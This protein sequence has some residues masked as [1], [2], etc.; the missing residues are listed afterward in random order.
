MSLPRANYFLSKRHLDV[1]YTPG[2]EALPE[3][4]LMKETLLRGPPNT[5][6]LLRY[7]PDS[8]LGPPVGDNTQLVDDPVFPSPTMPPRFF[9]SPSRCYFMP[10]FHGWQ[11]SADKEATVSE[12]LACSPPTK[13]IRVY[14][15][16]RVTHDFRT[17]ESCRVMRLVD[18]FS[19]GSHV[20]PAPLIPA[21]L[22][23]HLLPR[24]RCKEPL[25]NSILPPAVSLYACTDACSSQT[26]L[27]PKF[28]PLKVGISVRCDRL[29][30]TAR[31]GTSLQIA[32][33]FSDY[34]LLTSREWQGKRQRAAAC[35]TYIAAYV[36]NMFISKQTA[37]VAVTHGPPLTRVRISSLVVGR[38]VPAAGACPLTKV[39]KARRQVTWSWAPLTR[40]GARRSGGAR[41]APTA[42]ALYINS[43]HSATQGC[44]VPPHYRF[45]AAALATSCRLENVDWNMWVERACRLHSVAWAACKDMPMS[46]VQS[47]F[48][49]IV[50][51]GDWT[52]VLQEVSNTAWTNGVDIKQHRNA[53]AGKREIPEKTRRLGVSPDTIPKCENPGVT[54]PGIEPGSPWWEGSVCVAATLLW[55][56]FYP[57]NHVQMRTSTALKC[58]TPPVI[59]NLSIKSMRLLVIWWALDIH[60]TDTYH[61]YKQYPSMQ[62]EILQQ[63]S[64][65]P[66]IRILVDLSMFF[67][68]IA[69][70]KLHG[71][72][73]VML[74]RTIRALHTGHSVMLTSILSIGENSTA[75]SALATTNLSRTVARRK[76]YNYDWLVRR[77]VTSLHAIVKRASILHHRW[78]GRRGGGVA[79]VEAREAVP[80]VSEYIP[81]ISARR[82][83]PASSTGTEC[84][85]SLHS[86]VCSPR[87]CQHITHAGCPSLF[88]DDALASTNTLCALP[89]TADGALP[90]YLR[91]GVADLMSAGRGFAP[92]RLRVKFLVRLSHWEFI[93][94]SVS[95]ELD[96]VASI[97]LQQQR[98]KKR[99]EPAI[100]YFQDWCAVSTVVRGHALDWSA[101]P[102]NEGSV[103]EPRVRRVAGRVRTCYYYY[104]YYYGLGLWRAREGV[105]GNCDTMYRLFG[106][107]KARYMSVGR[108]Q[109]P[110]AQQSSGWPLLVIAT[111]WR[112]GGEPLGHS[113]DQESKIVA[114][115]V[116]CESGKFA[117]MKNKSLDGCEH[118]GREGLAMGV[119]IRAGVMVGSQE[120]R[121]T[122]TFLGT[123]YVAGST[124]GISRRQND[125]AVCSRTHPHRDV[126]L[127][128]EQISEGVIPFGM[129][130]LRGNETRH[131]AW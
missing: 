112:C 56:D 18:G 43:C 29:I 97:R 40:Q 114:I 92:Q 102:R 74:H 81:V 87:E 115:G 86:A 37:C 48:A 77:D 110:I 30:A 17:W 69:L 57:H 94:K 32:T 80:V 98:Q 121:E 34:A 21:L 36:A 99:I 14:S 116:E 12:R 52:T 53:I 76:R 120:E 41:P 19:R 26:A 90:P 64:L 127:L 66:S 1:F 38:A 31:S 42:S 88:P 125:R 28:N 67:Q 24:S 61:K 129:G 124:R 105:G 27:A 6:I 106:A 62:Q 5:W 44:T 82:G 63:H 96:N 45:L 109:L 47:L 59:D 9:A 39:G 84:A 49:F 89:P 101:S 70:H 15:P 95:L 50:E 25:W 33:H 85:R 7:P 8:S 51:C 78:Q 119:G 107:L 4:C 104:Y 58:Y 83:S 55:M 128:D 35:N 111:S 91:G 123:E 122:C 73:V 117:R 11:F 2:V 23:T 126:R 100:P 108:R 72:M 130:Q 103:H 10:C 71:T 13:A 16:I 68:C 79:D 54:R 93:S 113:R 131:L 22:Y 20:S 75:E 60:I 3:I 65:T 46:A 118:P